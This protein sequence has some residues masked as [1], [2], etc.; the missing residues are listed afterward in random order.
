[1]SDSAKL[2]LQRWLIT[3]CAVG[4][5]AHMVSGIKYDSWSGLVWASLLL[6]ILN[7]V[8]RPLMMLISLPLLV[9]SL[10]LF[11]I[12]INA[13][14]LYWVG[15]LKSFHVDSFGSAIKGSIVISLISLV[16]NLMTGSGNSSIKVRKAQASRKDNKGNDNDQGPVID[17]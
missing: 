6:G 12:V 1:M 11:M 4:V 14:L 3:T 15:H 17:V 16:L 13:V 10:G 7:A 2:F 8:V 5:A 9:L